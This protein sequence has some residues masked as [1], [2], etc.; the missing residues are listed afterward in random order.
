MMEEPDKDRRAEI[1]RGFKQDLKIRID[2]T[3]KYIRPKEGTTD[4]AFMFIPAEGVYASLLLYNV[5]AVNVSSRNLIE[6][7]FGKRVVIVSPSSFFAYL[8]TVLHALK[9]FEIEEGVKDIVKRVGELSRHMAN[10]S[11]YLKRLGSNLNTTVNTYNTTY[12]E[13]GK[14]DKD[15]LRI[16]GE[17]NKTEITELAGPEGE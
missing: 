3:A 2:E 7:A 4:F 11:E 15:V 1:E 10:H 14:I 8:Q 17:N 5:G 9:S 12:K 13:F 6:Y 16:T